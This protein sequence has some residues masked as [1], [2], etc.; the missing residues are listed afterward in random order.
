MK[1]E[2]LFKMELHE[3]KPFGVLKGYFN[4]HDIGEKYVTRVLNG[5]EYT[6]ILYGDG[7]FSVSTTFVPEPQEEIITGCPDR[8][9]ELLKEEKAHWVRVLDKGIS[10]ED[11]LDDKV[12]RRVAYAEVDRLESKIKNYRS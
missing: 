3:V 8:V 1:K 2:E 5:W 6:I 4:G 11:T 12:V 7:E 10:R 9:L